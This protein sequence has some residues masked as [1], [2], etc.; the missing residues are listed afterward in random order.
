MAHKIIDFYTNQEV[1]PSKVNKHSNLNQWNEFDSAVEAFKYMIDNKE[2]GCITLGNIIHKIEKTWK[3][4]EVGGLK[5]DGHYVWKNHLFMI[6]SRF[7]RYVGELK[8]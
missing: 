3:P 4:L 5:I 7:C 6:M 1:E 8:S 2:N